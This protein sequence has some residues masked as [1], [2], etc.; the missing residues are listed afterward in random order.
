VESLALFGPLSDTVLLLGLSATRVAV[1]FLLV[2][3][4]TAELVPAT[5]RNAVFVA[6][7]LLGLMLQPSAAPL[8]LTTW[9]WISTFGKEAF[10]G[11]TIGLLFAGVMWAFEAA[12]QLI[13]SKVGATQAQV[14]DPLSGH[15][16]SLNGAL[17]G[18]LASWVFMAYGG[19]MVMIG[20]LIESFALWPVRSGFPGLAEGGARVFEGELGRIMLLTLLV[21]A[22][23]LVLLYLVEGVLGLVNRF[24]QQLNVFSLSMSLKAIAATWI[25]W[26]QLTT[27]VRFL[28]DD[29][30]ARGGISLLTL[31]RL[32][33]A[34]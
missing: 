12:G 1:A 16:T 32:F 24:A 7:A 31:R 28:Q 13:D 33:G 25:I 29:M 26:I 3:L 23:A 30:L 20:T 21:A 11:G 5:V 18:R 2:P 27:L 19:F 17:L 34:E 14:M 15:Q 8:Q 9:Q 10:I 22:P 6:V 4:F